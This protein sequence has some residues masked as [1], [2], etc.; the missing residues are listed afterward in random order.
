MQCYRLHLVFCCLQ[1][2]RGSP[3]RR[4]NKIAASS[5]ICSKKE[6]QLNTCCGVTNVWMMQGETAEVRCCAAA[7]CPAL[8]I[9][10]GPSVGETGCPCTGQFCTCW[11]YDSDSHLQHE[12]MHFLRYVIILTV[13]SL[14]FSPPTLSLNPTFRNARTCFPLRCSCN[15][16]E[17][18]VTAFYS[19]GAKYRQQQNCVFVTA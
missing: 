12:A 7:A 6:V 13:S 1:T 10:S 11:S 8:A 3:L 15:R 2:T 5:V 14:Y 19:F 9:P 17:Q 16:D 18:P 4:P